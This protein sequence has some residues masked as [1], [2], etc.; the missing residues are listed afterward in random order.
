M[1]STGCVR[2]SLEGNFAFLSDRWAEMTKFTVQKAKQLGMR[3]DF[4]LGTGWPYGGPWITPELASKCITRHDGRSNGPDRYGVRIP[5]DIGEHEKLVGLFAAR[6]VGS[7]E[8]LDPP[9]HR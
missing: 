7:D 8:V 5:G 6:T 4:M 3:V 1:K 9:Q 2:W